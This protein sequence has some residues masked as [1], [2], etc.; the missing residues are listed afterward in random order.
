[1]SAPARAVPGSAQ[2]LATVLDAGSF[3]SWD[4][5]A[6]PPAGADARYRRELAAARDA[7]GTDESMVSGEGRVG[8]RR[9]AV[10][11]SEFGFLAGSVG[12]TAARRLVAAVERATDERLPLLLSPASGGTRMQ[13]GTPAF[14]EM[15]T[16]AD[17]VA[18]HRRAGLPVVVHLRHPATG[19]AFASWGSLGTVTTAEPGALVGFLG[20]KVYRALH[21]TDFP[22]DVQRSENLAARGI[23]DAVTGADGLARLLDALLAVVERRPTVAPAAPPSPEPH[24]GPAPDAWASITATRRPDRPGVRELLDREAGDVVPL[25]GTGVGEIAAAT[26]LCL[27]RIGSTPCVLVGQDRA[28]ERPPG[29]A[30]LRVARRGF[31]LARELRLPLVTVVDTGGGELSADAENG[32]LAGEIARCLAELADLPVPSVSVLAG[33]G[34]GGAALALFGSRRRIAAGNA[35]LTPLPPEGASAIVHGTPD[36]AAEVVAAQQVR[37]TDLADAGAVDRIVPE[38]PDAADEPAAFTARLARAI[39]EEV[40]IAATGPGRRR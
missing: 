20:P 22:P 16:I 34:S 30:D 23:V 39:E 40:R 37:A 31:A 29:P 38:H 18:A 19:G 5:P 11:V 14:L 28:A 2:L 15:I 27:A 13:E 1:M 3:R 21:G 26:V 24:G 25:H 36:R 12:S 35:W 4:A 10:A 6:T 32:A 17:R 9:L 8:G 33:Q 7:A